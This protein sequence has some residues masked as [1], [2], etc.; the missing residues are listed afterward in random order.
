[1]H[2]SKSALAGGASLVLLAFAPAVRAS[3]AV[4]APP[5]ADPLEPPHYTF[6]IDVG[7][8][9]RHFP[10]LHFHVE[11][12][13]SYEP[14]QSYAVHFDKLPWFVPQ[15]QH[16]T[17]LSMLDPIMWPQRFTYQQI[18]ERDGNTLYMLHSLSDATLKGATVTIGPRGHAR[19]VDATYTDG[20]KIGMTVSSSE[21]GG[22]LLPATLNADIDEPHMALSANADFKNYEF[23]GEAAAPSPSQ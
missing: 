10:W 6:Q 7:M 18:G 15:Q 5:F 17:D 16:D 9:M 19:R 12:N 2:V 22:F 8:A 21:I 20:T 4:S 13:G 3:A 14:G 11:G 1:M 23:A